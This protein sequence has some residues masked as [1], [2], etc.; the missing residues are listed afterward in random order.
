MNNRDVLELIKLYVSKLDGAQLK[1]DKMG[2]YGPVYIIIKRNCV[3]I[4]LYVNDVENTI[5][6]EY[7]RQKTALIDVNNYEAILNESLSGENYQ[8]IKLD[9]TGVIT[10][11]A[12]SILHSFVHYI[13]DYV[14]ADY[15]KVV[16]GFGR[17]KYYS[18]VLDNYCIFSF[19]VENDK[20]YDS[21]GQE[22]REE[23]IFKILNNILKNNKPLLIK[24]RVW[25][26]KFI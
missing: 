3:P 7:L 1:Y 26:Q 18:L 16:F 2:D 5:E 24:A 25:H 17:D 23:N 11:F 10:N 14:K 8:F 19:Y 6:I 12:W 15:C 4:F 9:D 13:N 21:L 20:V 22:L